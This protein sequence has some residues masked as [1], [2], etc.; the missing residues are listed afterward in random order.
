MHGYVNGLAIDRRENKNKKK[1]QKYINRSNMN[2]WVQNLP[3]S[4]CL[5]VHQLQSSLFN[6]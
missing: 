4:F 2:H 6:F 5:V 1:L 3:L